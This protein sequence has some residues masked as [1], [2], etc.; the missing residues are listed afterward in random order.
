MK[1]APPEILPPL[2]AKWMIELLPD[3]VQSESLADC[4]N[5]PMCHGELETELD[6]TFEPWSKCCTYIPELPNFLVGRVLNNQKDKSNSVI[7][8]IGER[9]KTR[10]AVTPKGIAILAS[11]KKRYK[12][13][14][15]KNRFGRTGNSYRCPYY[16][17]SDGLCG[18]YESRPAACSTW[19]CKYRRG[20]WGQRFWESIRR[21]LVEIEKSLSSW[22]M[23]GLNVKAL[24]YLAFN[25]N[26]PI[27][28]ALAAGSIDVDLYRHIWGQFAG[29]EKS[30]YIECAN[31]VEQL[32]WSDVLDITGSNVRFQAAVA[33]EAQRQMDEE[34]F[35]EE[36]NINSHQAV[37]TKTGMMRIRGYSAY[38][39]F[40][41]PP[42]VGSGLMQALQTARNPVKTTDIVKK[43]E[44]AIGYTLQPCHIKALFVSGILT[45]AYES[46]SPSTTATP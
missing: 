38:H 27:A 7:S 3:R 35:P 44:S 1:K 14:T 13:S 28:G 16:V 20:F 42:D 23:L 32:S 43:V 21:V 5:C 39:L 41:F 30:F 29:T 40:D 25:N 17:E 6:I 10:A 11:D 19:F 15:S 46:L 8:T 33:C 34:N 18:I 4:A 45:P 2:Y 24:N 26:E 12:E 22:C 36:V 37:S 9:I 31:W